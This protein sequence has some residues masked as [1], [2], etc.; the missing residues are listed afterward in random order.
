MK[1]KLSVLE[2]ITLLGILP[3]MENY[4]TIKVV[5]DIHSK[6]GIDDKEA[7]AIDF[8]VKGERVEWDIAKA[9]DK[10]FEIGAFESDIIR[11]ALE[12]LD[13][14]KKLEPRHISLWEKFVERKE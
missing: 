8:V 7:K 10:E 5:S 13:K 6:L 3:S 14:E 1:V 4:A 11:L 12:K 9:K 2:R